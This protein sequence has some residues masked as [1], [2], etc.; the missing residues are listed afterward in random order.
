MIKVL[1]HSKKNK[2]LITDFLFSI[3]D[4]FE[5][6]L[7]K[8]LFAKS[9]AQSFQDYAEKIL[10]FASCI[11]VFIDDE[12]KGLLVIYHNDE[13]NQTAYIP[14]LAVFPSYSGQGLA[15]SLIKEAIRQSKASQMKHIFVNTWIANK[16]AIQL[17]QKNG[18]E[19]YETLGNDV[20]LK[21][22]II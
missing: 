4:Y 6:V 15:S 16:K 2:N 19:I 18:F 5:P 22:N 14:I 11:G 10:R 8:R 1:R 13:I 20:K 7:E 3:N 12:L 21:Y 9:N 17:Y